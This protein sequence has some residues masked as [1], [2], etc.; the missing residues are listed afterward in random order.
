MS[1]ITQ[2]LNN[3]FVYAEKMRNGFVSLHLLMNLIMIGKV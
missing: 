2:P 3:D 1:K